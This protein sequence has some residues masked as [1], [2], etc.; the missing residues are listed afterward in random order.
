MLYLVVF[1]FFFP[2]LHFHDMCRVYFTPN[3]PLAG[4]ALVGVP[5]A[6]GYLVVTAESQIQGQPV[7]LRIPFHLSQCPLGYFAPPTLRN[8]SAAQEIIQAVVTQRIPT[9]LSQP[10]ACHCFKDTS[11]VTFSRFVQ[12]YDSECI[13]GYT[14]QLSSSIWGGLFFE[15]G[16]AV[17]DIYPPTV[18]CPSQE[19][20]PGN[21][22][23]SDNLTNFVID[24]RR[25]ELLDQELNFDPV[26][27]VPYLGLV[28]P[29]GGASVMCFDK[30]V[31]EVINHKS[32]G[33]FT[34]EQCGQ[35][36]CRGDGR[37]TW[38]VANVSFPCADNRMGPLCGQCK[39]N[40]S[41]SLYSTVSFD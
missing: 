1:L 9:G 24:L 21:F 34:I 23:F 35:G 12:Q 40:Y 7:V 17:D 19:T 3:R 32:R 5:G 33:V 2:F 31:S 15:D 28:S 25:M 20:V 22:T 41:V 11:L 26:D 36:Y 10:L 38:V 6:R 29:G 37:D 30:N 27:V 16:K 18:P 39:P 13:L 8:A 14:V 4:L